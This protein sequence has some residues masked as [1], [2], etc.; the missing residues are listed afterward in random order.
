MGWYR[1]DRYGLDWIDMV[2]DRDQWK[3]LVNTMMNLRVPS[4]S[5]KFLSCC[6]GRAQ[7]R[8]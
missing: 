1:L 3:A 4:N 6:T 8:K 7:L 2:K 5:G